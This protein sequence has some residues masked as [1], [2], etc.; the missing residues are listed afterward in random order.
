VTGQKRGVIDLLLTDVIMP[1]MSG[2]QLAERIVAEDPRVRVV[3]MSGHSEEIIATRGV[4]DPA[5][6]FLPKPIVAGALLE[7]VREMLAGGELRPP[8]GREMR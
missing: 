8:L 6:H 5:V 4:L 3:Y 2:K 7:L 1:Q